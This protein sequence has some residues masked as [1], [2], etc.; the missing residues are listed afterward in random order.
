LWGPLT[1]HT[2]NNSVLNLVHIR[3]IDGLDA[4]TMVLNVVMDVGFAALLLWTKL[5]AKRLHTSELEPWGTKHVQKRLEASY[6][7]H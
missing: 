2:I 5:W 6:P 7:I 1:A 4:D 3:T